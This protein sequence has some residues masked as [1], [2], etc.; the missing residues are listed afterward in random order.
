MVT[1]HDFGVADGRVFLIMELVD[2][3]TLRREMQEVGRIE[4]ARVCGLLR[5]ICA[6]V[7]EAHRHKLVHRD[8]KP[9]NVMLTGP[10]RSVPKILDFGVAKLVR[11]DTTGRVAIDSEIGMI[12]GTL[13]VHGA[14]TAPR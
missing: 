4:P 7:E 10:G 3:V 12:V 1:V 2:G 9:E 5:G 13:Q 6:A 14:R 11:S 8:L